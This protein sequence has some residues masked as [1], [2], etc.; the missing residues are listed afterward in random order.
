MFVLFAEIL[1]RIL[2]EGFLASRRAEVIGL[3]LVF[4][5]S[6]RGGGVNVHVA[7][8]VMYGI[9]HD[10]LLLLDSIRHKIDF[11]ARHRITQG[12]YAILPIFRQAYIRMAIGSMNR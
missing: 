11:V 1:L 5:R 2:I 10:W 7:D 3:S 6:S 4:G 9:V 8:G 12:I